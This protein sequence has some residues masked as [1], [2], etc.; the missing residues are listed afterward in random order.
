VLLASEE[1]GCCM[2]YLISFEVWVS[3]NPWL[4]NWPVTES[5]PV[6][7]VHSADMMIEIRSC[8]CSVFCAV[9]QNSESSYIISC[10]EMA[11]IL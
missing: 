7:S 1:W 6:Q 11:D 4:C 3:R 9:G 8:S 2:K 10:P 5:V